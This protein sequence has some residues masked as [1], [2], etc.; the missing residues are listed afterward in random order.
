M[1]TPQRRMKS[2]DGP[3][4][5]TLILSAAWRLTNGAFGGTP[6]HD[7]KTTVDASVVTIDRIMPIS[8]DLDDCSGHLVWEKGPFV[9]LP[10]T[11][12]HC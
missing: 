2:A 3:I 7:I 12:C 8:H 4:N 1:Q 10:G 11:P 9:Q 5:T 6:P